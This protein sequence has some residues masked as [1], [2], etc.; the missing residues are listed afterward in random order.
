MVFTL[1]QRVV[2]PI[3]FRVGP[4]PLDGETIVTWGV[5]IVLL[6]A[7]WRIGRRASRGEPSKALTVCETLIDWL[8]GEIESVM[9]RDP[10]PFIGLVGGV[11]LFI[12][13]CNLISPLGI[14]PPTAYITT[15]GA[16][17]LVV[18]ASVPYYAISLIGVGSY[19]RTYLEPSPFMLPLNIISE[20]SRTLAL[21]VRLFGNMFSG[22][23]LIGMVL[24]LVPFILPLPLMF[25]S[26]LTG[27]IQAYIFAVLTMVYIGSTVRSAARHQPKEEP[28]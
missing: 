10:G 19:L 3:W 23:I 15:T 25:L 5:M 14:K 28:E 11:F 22:E 17:A 20:L 6:T 7:A 27:T 9:G 21:A 4:V 24:M 8:Q 12:F 26:L 13:V 1:M 2:A 16:L 18:F